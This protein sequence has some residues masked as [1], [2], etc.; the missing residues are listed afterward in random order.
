MLFVRESRKGR[1]GRKN[2]KDIYSRR[3]AENAEV[4]CVFCKKQYRFINLPLRPLRLC[5]RTVV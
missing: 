4:T 3:G 2:A 5:E 1:K